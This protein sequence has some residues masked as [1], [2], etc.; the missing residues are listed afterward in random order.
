MVALEIES[1]FSFQEKRWL[2][3]VAS[4]LLNDTNREQL[5]QAK[6]KAARRAAAEKR[7]PK[8]LLYTEG[9]PTKIPTPA[10]ARLISEV[11]QEIADIMQ[12]PVLYLAPDAIIARF[13]E[14]IEEKRQKEKRN[15]KKKTS[16]AAIKPPHQAHIF[17]QTT[18]W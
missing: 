5:E 3:D 12:L 17:Q 11:R 6:N 9:W 16:K 13:E 8:A 15:R 2:A 4:H 7:I 18:L 1:T 10:E 14:L